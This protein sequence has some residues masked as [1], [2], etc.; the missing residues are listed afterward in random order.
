[1]PYIVCLTR[2]FSNLFQN[3]I[4]TSPSFLPPKHIFFQ[5]TPKYPVFPRGIVK[6]CIWWYA[7]RRLLT[8]G[9]NP[10]GY[11]ALSAHYAV[12]LPASPV[13]RW[14]KSYSANRTRT[15]TSQRMP[16][17][18]PFTPLH[19]QSFQSTTISL[20]H[21]WDMRFKVYALQTYPGH[22]GILCSL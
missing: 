12:V 19:Y 17:M 3:I 4:P 11:T 21:T 1:M 7:K 22:Q 15:D 6:K 2:R 18:L 9:D 14:Q 5:Y 8:P 10:G 13:I 16:S 20:S